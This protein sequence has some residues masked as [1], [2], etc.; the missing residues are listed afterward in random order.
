[1]AV[2]VTRNINGEVVHFCSKECRDRY[3]L[4]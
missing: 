1:V 3:S 4:H 2:S